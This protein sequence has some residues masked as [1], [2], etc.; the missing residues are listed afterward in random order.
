[1]TAISEALQNIGIPGIDAESVTPVP[2]A[3]GWV[4]GD[5]TYEVRAPYDGRLLGS[6]PSLAPADVD[7]AV[8]AAKAALRG[9]AF[10]QWRR[11][12]VLDAAA[13]RLAAHQ[14]V[15]ARC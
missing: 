3:S 10:P 13:Q 12:Q 1:M 15:F 2:I 4:T 11:A 6:V 9:V 5:A 8:A 14:D 7:R